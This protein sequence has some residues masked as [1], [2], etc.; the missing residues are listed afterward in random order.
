MRE[1]STWKC[2]ACSNTITVFVPLKEAP[3]CSTHAK[4]GRVMKKV[5][6]DRH[7]VAE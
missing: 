1:V 3:I 2:P 4:G 7:Q 5:E 6:D